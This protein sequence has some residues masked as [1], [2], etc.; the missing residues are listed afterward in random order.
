MII[1]AA[2]GLT[3]AAPACKSDDQPAAKQKAET[4]QE[5]KSLVQQAKLPD[6][7]VAGKTV[8]VAKFIESD[9]GKVYFCCDPCIEKYRADPGK[10]AVQVAA[11]REAFKLV[12]LGG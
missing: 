5:P 7:P 1:A 6:C 12:S 4:K 9:E 3:L 2:L 11:Q 10:Y 8:N